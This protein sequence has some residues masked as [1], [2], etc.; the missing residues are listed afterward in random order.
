L[1]RK[2]E[3]GYPSRW[4]SRLRIQDEE[5]DEEEELVYN[6]DL[7]KFTSQFSNTEKRAKD[8]NKLAQ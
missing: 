2:R 3:I 8:E 7:E 4:L 5:E 1:S 6:N